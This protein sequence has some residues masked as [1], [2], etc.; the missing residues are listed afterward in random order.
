MG[1]R[2]S[3]LRVLPVLRELLLNLAAVG[4]AL[5]VLLVILALLLDITLI[6]FKT[7]SMAPSIPAG[8]VAVVQEIPAS[9]VHVTDVVTVDR[10][11]ALPITHR[12]TSIKDAGGPARTITMKGDANVAGDPAPYTVTSVRRVLFSVPRLAP[13][14]VRMSEPA[15]M[16]VITLA[17][18]GLVT[19]GSWPTRTP[20]NRTTP[21]RTTPTS[22]RH[23][24][25]DSDLFHRKSRRRA[26][27]RA[28]RRAVRSG[29]LGRMTT[30]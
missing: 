15:V 28:E 21:A 17:V 18:A 12:V 2:P 10:A 6:M 9:D 13:V 24:T 29:A 4:G 22:P 25:R 14:I 19:W 8:S 20:A 26:D 16:A 23:G 27:H 5:C 30:K 11:G 1:R 3:S 7:G